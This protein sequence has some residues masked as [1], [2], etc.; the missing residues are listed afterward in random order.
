MALTAVHITLVGL[1]LLTLGILTVYGMHRYVQVYLYCRHHHKAPTPAG[2]FPELPKVTVQLPMY[3]EMYVARRIIEG[4]C[5]LDYPREKLEI[6]VLDDSTDDSA[7]IA[8]KCCEEMRRLGHNVH[9]IH[10]TN[11][12]GY[13]AGA[14]AHG[15]TQATGEFVVIFDADF[16]PA[17]EMI[18]Q[19]IH[20]FT[21]PNV[22]CV[23]TRWDHMNR[24]DS[25]LTRCQAIFL[26][27]HF[28]IEHTARNRSGRFINFNGTAGIWRRK[29]IED[30]GG[31]QHDT[32]TEDVD[33][34]YRAQLRGWRFVFL[35][36]LLAPAE[37]PP[38]IVGFKQ[39]QHRW[40]K[41]Q[42]QTAVKLL[43]SILRAPLPLR[44]KTEAFF[45]LTSP[46]VYLPAIV[47]SLILF[48]VWFV[49]PEL[50][51][52][53]RSALVA[54]V[55]ASFCG[56]L[57]ASAGTFYMLSQKAVGRSQWRTVLLVPF[58]MAIGMGISVMNGLAVLEGLFGR[59]D[60]EFVRT[61][62]YGANGPSD[63]KKKAG[64]YN[65]KKLSMLP[66]IEILFGVYLAACAIAAIFT[67]MAWG[68][69]PFLIIF[70]FGYLYVGLL[71]FHG[72]W[73]ANRVQ[74]LPQR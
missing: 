10:R 55:I 38:E 42:V 7:Q 20:F 44:V 30:S 25:L 68:T 14:L 72:R 67:R 22:G 31:W 32:L 19:S 70:S 56:L 21:D 24:R 43:P 12:Q 16:V 65:K 26:D 51:T 28:M 58:L 15:L 52:V 45:H 71:T 11:R 4:A 73:L 13:K 62:K 18:R 48:P 54:M 50:F 6:Q 34:S 2:T 36:E 60:T 59:K 1:Y 17:K 46:A 23:Q 40:T 74:P 9:Y 49:D 69:A 57:T 39:Q 66:F 61:P 33:L 41:G 35:P 29:A 3:N 8:A 63:W 53:S 27:G 5:A 47:L 37:L 64:T